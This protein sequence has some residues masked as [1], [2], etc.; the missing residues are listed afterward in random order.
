MH[1][2]KKRPIYRAVFFV[3][4]YLDVKPKGKFFSSY[5][6]YVTKLMKK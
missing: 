3:S 4:I 1:K 2:Q 6:L 5:F